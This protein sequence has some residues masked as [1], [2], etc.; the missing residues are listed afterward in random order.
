MF[1]K[2]LPELSGNQIL[3]NSERVMF[4]SKTGEMVTFAKGKL[5]FATDSEM[6]LNAVKRIVTTTSQHTS[7]VSPTIHLGAY[8]T[9][10]HPVLKGDITTNWLSSLCGWLSSH[11]H[12]DPYITTGPP[13]QQ[14]TLAG[15]RARLPTLHS[16]RVWIDG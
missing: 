2:Q 1:G 11:V 7:V 3:I 14:G 15:L 9:T 8:T 13:A 6:T 12:N 5:G 10:R 4:S 16:T